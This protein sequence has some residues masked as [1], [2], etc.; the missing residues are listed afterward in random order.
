VEY[1]AAV[2][3]DNEPEITRLLALG[4]AANGKL[5]HVAGLTPAQRVEY[6]AAVASNNE[7]EITRLLALGAAAN[8]K[9][10]GT[11]TRSTLKVPGCKLTVTDTSRSSPRQAAE[12]GS[13]SSRRAAR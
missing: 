11:T 12:R 6:D 10:G 2:D 4:A 9:L 3:S 8:G 13:A 7:P 1:N 5:G